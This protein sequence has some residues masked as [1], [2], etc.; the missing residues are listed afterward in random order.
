MIWVETWEEVA[1][2]EEEQSELYEELL[3]WVKTGL[4]NRKRGV[5]HR[6]YSPQAAR[7]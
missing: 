7:F 6:S 3:T 5:V 4:F 1:L 2:S